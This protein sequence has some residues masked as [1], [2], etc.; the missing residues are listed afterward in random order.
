MSHAEPDPS[1]SFA[2]KASFT[3]VPSLG[4]TT[5]DYYAASFERANYR[6]VE[7]A[8]IH[9]PVVDRARESLRERAD[10]AIDALRE[11]LLKEMRHLMKAER[12]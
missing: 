12:T 10:D 3:N 1:V 5:A 8:A 6:T 4:D 2:K 7:E 9:L 11:A